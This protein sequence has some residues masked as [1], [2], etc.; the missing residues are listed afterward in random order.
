MNA[1]F[2][3]RPLLLAFIAASCVAAG[4]AAVAAYSVRAERTHGMRPEGLLSF[5]E[6]S[7]WWLAGA[8]ATFAYASAGAYLLRY[9][10]ASGNP[11]VRATCLVAAIALGAACP[12]AVQAAI[13]ATL[14]TRPGFMC[15]L[16]GSLLIW[17]PWALGVIAIIIDATIGRVGNTTVAAS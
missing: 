3:I 2:T 10:A 14:A 9:R 15:I 11:L 1:R 12:L 16:P 13:D 6:Q 8:A 5:R 17:S 4:G 7:S